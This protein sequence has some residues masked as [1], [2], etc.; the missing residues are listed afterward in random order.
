VVGLTA[1]LSA[2]V[3]AISCAKNFK[4]HVSISEGTSDRAIV[5]PM[6][7]LV[8]GY[9][10]SAILVLFAIGVLGDGKWLRSVL[11]ASSA[12][13]LLSVSTWRLRR[14]AGLVEERPVRSSSDP[15]S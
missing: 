1:L 7:L 5:L 4:R 8:F 13:F 9:G 11:L 6:L 3:V 10:S 14:A 15:R 12:V 2:P